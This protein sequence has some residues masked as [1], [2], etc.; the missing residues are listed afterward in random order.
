MKHCLVIWRHYSKIGEPLTPKQI[1]MLK[2]YFRVAYRS[3][4]KNKSYV[5]IN[6][7]GLGISLAC[8][9]TAY[10]ILAFNIEFD[11][12]HANNKVERIYKVHSHFKEKDGK[13]TQ[14]NN[15]PIVLAPIASQEISGIERFTRFVRDGAYMRYGTQS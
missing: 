1:V 7:L 3:L 14:N 9:I 15:A 13:I 2:N 12:F 6:T 4:L 8:C 5:I 10:L 11:S